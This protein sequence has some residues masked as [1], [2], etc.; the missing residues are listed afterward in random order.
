VHRGNPAVLSLR[1]YSETGASEKVQ[2]EADRKWFPIAAA[3]RPRLKA[4]VYVV[5][6]A[7]C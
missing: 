5:A 6:V 4:I 2:L 3:R 1:R 7:A